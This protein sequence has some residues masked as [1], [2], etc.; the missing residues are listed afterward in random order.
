MPVLLGI[1]NTDY[2]DDLMQYFVSIVACFT[3]KLCGQRH[4]K[5]KR[6]RLI[7]E[8]GN[9]KIVQMSSLSQFSINIQVMK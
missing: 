8:L 6:E 9:E 7:K 1:V 5:R 3:A 4:T 2:R